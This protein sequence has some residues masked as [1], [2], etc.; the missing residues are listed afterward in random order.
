MDNGVNISHRKTIAIDVD[1]VLAISVPAFV[2]F[3]N[4]HFGT[5]LTVD[6]YSEN[7]LEVWQTDFKGMSERSKKM[8]D[9]GF[10][11]KL[12]S[13]TDALPV[14]TELSTKYNLIIT[15]SR[16]SKL[17]IITNAWLNEYFPD[18]FTSIYHAGF[19]DKTHTNNGSTREY[20]NVAVKSTKTSLCVENEADY[21]IDDHPK[22]CLGAAEN[23]ITALLFGDYPWNRG[24]KLPQ[25]VFKVKNWSEIRKFF[26][27]ER[28]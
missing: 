21:L 6:D 14:L 9:S 5:N 17:N 16:A 26:K 1:D 4:K 8:V 10:W 11:T 13:Y 2:D 12:E 28:K 19:F 18:I 24:H 22:H 15:T 27:N 3:S 23:G 20:I 7:W 25:G